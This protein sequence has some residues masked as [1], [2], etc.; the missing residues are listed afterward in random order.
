MAACRTFPGTVTRT[1][2]RQP[3]CSSSVSTRVTPAH[4]GNTFMVISVNTDGGFLVRNSKHGGANSPFTLTVFNQGRVF[5]INI[6][7]RPDGLLALGKEKT[8]ENV[9]Y[10]GEISSYFSSHF[11]HIPQLEK[12]WRITRQRL[13]SSRPSP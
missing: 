4:F 2:P 10:K 5:N 6:R 8:D 1:G 3:S 13:S 11:R 7:V 12:W 9:R